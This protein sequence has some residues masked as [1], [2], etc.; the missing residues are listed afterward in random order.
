MGSLMLQVNQPEAAIRR[1]EM[2]V[3]FGMDKDP[4]IFRGL[5]ITNTLAGYPIHGLQAARACLQL[6]ASESQQAACQAVIT[7]TENVLTD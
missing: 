4:E 3:R 2:A 5:A 6:E 1:F 7:A